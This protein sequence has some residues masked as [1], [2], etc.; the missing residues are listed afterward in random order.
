MDREHR[1][2]F[3]AGRKPGQCR[4]Q[5]RHQHALESG[6]SN[7][8]LAGASAGCLGERLAASA[9]KRWGSFS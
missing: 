9:F 7:H 8:A 6:Y 1:R 4:E 2:L 3:S 5:N